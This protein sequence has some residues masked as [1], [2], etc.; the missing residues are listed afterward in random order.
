MNLSLKQ[1]LTDIKNRLVGE[2]WEERQKRD[3]MGV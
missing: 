3:G 1:T 2:K